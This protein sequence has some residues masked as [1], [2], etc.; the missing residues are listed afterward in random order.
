M[1][2]VF[3]CWKG[4]EIPFPE[5]DTI[6][7]KKD[8]VVSE[9][10][11]NSND[12]AGCDNEHISSARDLLSYYSL[13]V[14]A[15]GDLIGHHEDLERKLKESEKSAKTLTDKLRKAAGEL[16]GTRT[17]LAETEIKLKTTTSELKGMQSAVIP[18]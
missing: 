8:P 9:R 15:I 3:G 5:N 16:N 17:K 11:V 18:C 12:A 2:Q 1:A 7:T 14:R 13:H 10:P 6:I 4:T